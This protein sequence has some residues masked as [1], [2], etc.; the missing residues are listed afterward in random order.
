MGMYPGII[1]IQSCKVGYGGCRV[2]W[3]FVVLL[4]RASQLVGYMCGQCY[5][6]QYLV[7]SGNGLLTMSGAYVNNLQDVYD[8]DVHR[9]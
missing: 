1:G 5:R 3:T 6:R 2:L 9:Y 8:H 7:C 4:G